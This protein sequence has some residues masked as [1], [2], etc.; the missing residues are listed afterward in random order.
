[1]DAKKAVGSFERII[2]TPNKSIEIDKSL[3]SAEKEQ[4]GEKKLKQILSR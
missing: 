3:V 1:M 4:R 2:Y